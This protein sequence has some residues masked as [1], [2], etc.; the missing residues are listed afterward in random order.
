M[1][2]TKF[3]LNTNKNI[4]KKTSKDY[5]NTYPDCFFSILGSL[6]DYDIEEPNEIPFE[7]DKREEL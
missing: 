1:S 7:Y 5:S 2:I 3:N 6:K 4:Y